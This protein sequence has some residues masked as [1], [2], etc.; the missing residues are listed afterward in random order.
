MLPSFDRNGR[1]EWSVADHHANVYTMYANGLALLHTPRLTASIPPDLLLSLRGMLLC[2][3]LE[4]MGRI[5][6]FAAPRCTATAA[7]WKSM[8]TAIFSDDI[9]TMRHHFCQGFDSRAGNVLSI[10]MSLRAAVKESHIDAVLSYIANGAVQPS[11]RAEVS[12]P[13]DANI[14]EVNMVGML[15]AAGSDPDDCGGISGWGRASLA[16]SAQRQERESIISG[17]MTP[18]C[19][20]LQKGRADLVR[21]LIAA[22][23]DVNKAARDGDGATPLCIAVAKSRETTISKGWSLFRSVG[24][25]HRITDERTEIVAALLRAGALPGV[26]NKKTGETPLFV[27]VRKCSV[28]IAEQL[29][30][31]RRLHS[32]GRF[33][34]EHKLDAVLERHSQELAALDE[35]Y[36]RERLAAQKHHERMLRA[37]EAQHEAELRDLG[38][39]HREA[40]VE[41]ELLCVH[42]EVCSLDCE[43]ERDDGQTLL[44][45]AARHGHD[46]IVPLLLRAGARVNTVSSVAPHPTPLLLASMC[47]HPAMVTALLAAGAVPD[48]GIDIRSAA[49]C[50][51]LLKYGYSR[52]Q[53]SR[54]L[55]A[56]AEDAA[57]T[58]PRCTVT[59]LLLAVVKG[60]FGIAQLLAEAGADRKEKVISGMQVSF[61]SSRVFGAPNS[62]QCGSTG[63]VVAFTM[64]LVPAGPGQL[65]HS[66]KT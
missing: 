3:R 60:H 43:H 61:R 35:Q 27:A 33:D 30:S 42:K 53:V 38:V 44:L 57:S 16:I 19:F 28:S 50:D 10:A 51:F 63:S 1:G 54:L 48:C 58:P 6:R 46:K 7:E 12:P 41:A 64:N 14:T 18:L 37:T 20:A 32:E 66:W 22:G 40:Q 25:E 9:D 29:I 55:R 15:L 45:V 23:A 56:A 13:L 21:I 39:V 2:N 24:R 5:V 17:V 31:A 36:A 34:V 47:G 11:S 65:G 52:E 59:P 49:A 62:G 26:P 4:V 8:R